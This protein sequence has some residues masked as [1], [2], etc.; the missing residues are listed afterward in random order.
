MEGRTVRSTASP[1]AAGHTHL[2]AALA[3]LHRALTVGDVLELTVEIGGEHRCAGTGLGSCSPWSR[4]VDALSDLLVGG[5]FAVDHVAGPG[6]AVDGAL[7]ARARR[8]RTLPD[9]V[10]PGMRLLVCG[11]NPSSY[12]ADA[13]VPFARPGNR[14]WPAAQAA[15]LVATD[16]SPG[17]A[18]ADHGV[19]LTD[20]VKRATAGAAELSADEYRTGLGRLER[21]VR[22]LRPGA[23]CVVGLAGWRAAV[24]RR[25]VPGPQPTGLGGVAVHLMPSTSG[26]N[27]RTSLAEL[28]GHLRAAAGLADAAPPQAAMPSASSDSPPPLPR[29]CRR[30]RQDMSS[31]TSPPKP[32]ASRMPRPAASKVW[33]WKA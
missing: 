4:P 31:S 7:V 18:L 14:F 3:D 6:R 17:S 13:G 25:A 30:S 10:G 21:L 32:T 22:W 5:G 2:P 29:P 9:T 28:A 24:D 11:L 20:L 33:P 23:L 12:A 1:S 15:G 19:G 27:A 16:R 26:R 8:A